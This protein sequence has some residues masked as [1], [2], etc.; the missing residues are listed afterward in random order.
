MRFFIVLVAIVC[1]IQVK[2]K[3]TNLKSR[4]LIRRELKTYKKIEKKQSKRKYKIHDD[5]D[6]IATVQNVKIDRKIVGYI[7]ANMPEKFTIA[8]VEAALKKYYD[9]LDRIITRSTKIRYRWAY[10][11]HLLG[12][13]EIKE[14]EDGKYSWGDFEKESPSSPAK[15]SDMEKWLIDR[16]PRKPFTI[17]DFLK[18]YPDT[19]RKK[20]NGSI[21]ELVKRD[22]LQQLKNDQ[23]RL[24]R[25][26]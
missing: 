18:D 9:K 21:S 3:Q 14:L 2:Q 12:A 25:I 19:D 11:N 22:V 16:L 13:G 1:I 6:V 4:W 7:K 24:R 8:D 15:Y 5:K 20:L 10:M 17:N 23:F 26:A